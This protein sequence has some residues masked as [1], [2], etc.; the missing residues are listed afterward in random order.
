MW[1]CY[2]DDPNDD[3][4]L[5]ESFKYKIKIAEKT[6]ADGNTKEAKIAVPLKDLS[7]FWRTRE[8][9]LI[10]CEIYLILTWCEDCVISSATGEKKFKIAD[11]KIYVLVP[12][13]VL[14]VGGGRFYVDS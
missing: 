8:I 11:T 6:P 7:Y 3:I 12:G 1:Q 5:Y 4:T 10:N 13:Q 9:P 2:R 14:N